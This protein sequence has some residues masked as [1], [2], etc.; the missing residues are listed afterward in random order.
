[1]RCIICSGLVVHEKL[2]DNGMAV[3][4]FRCV[5]CATYT[6]KK[7]EE[8]DFDRCLKHNRGY[9]GICERIEERLLK[10]KLLEGVE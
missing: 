9:C 7:E 5:M 2:N 8:K 4:S 10:K 1:M 3:P 6:F